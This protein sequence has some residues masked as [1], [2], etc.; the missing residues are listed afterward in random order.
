MKLKEYLKREKIGLEAKINAQV[1]L[2]YIVYLKKISLKVTFFKSNHRILRKNKVGSF[3][4]GISPAPDYTAPLF[5][6]PK[7]ILTLF[8]Y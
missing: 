7:C 4:W 1:I 5:S 6:Q 8:V 3:L 2:V